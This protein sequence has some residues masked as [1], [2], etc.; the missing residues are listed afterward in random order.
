MEP[1]TEIQKKFEKLPAVIREAITSIDFAEK[2]QNIGKANNLHLDELDA[3]FEEVGFVM[4]GETRTQDFAGKISQRLG[5]RI[6]QISPLVKSVDEEI[7]RPIRTALISLHDTEQPRRVT[8]IPI[9]APRP[10]S[11]SQV[12]FDAKEAI[13]AP[14]IPSTPE[15]PNSPQALGDGVVVTPETNALG[16]EPPTRESLLKD[17]ETT[18]SPESTPHRQLEPQDPH[19]YLL[20]KAELLKKITGNNMGSGDVGV[21]SPKKKSLAEEAIL[22]AKQKVD[23]NAISM[24]SIIAE[25]PKPTIPLKSAEVAPPA[26]VP[27]TPKQAPLTPTATPQNEVRP[28]PTFTP[29][30]ITPHSEA[31]EP[32]SVPFVNLTASSPLPLHEVSG[33]NKLS[34][35]VQVPRVMSKVEAPLSANSTVTSTPLTAK[36]DPYREQI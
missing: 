9:P 8:D 31:M 33:E 20:G 15:T 26:F 28:E 16:E 1:L 19:A 4:L 10:S 17:I 25:A 29:P 27:S 24:K 14:S 2:L 11:F 22:V 3:L 32:K 12:T 34:A 5:L 36:V 18:A 21:T 23:P 13:L 35:V 7:F 30:T 6:D